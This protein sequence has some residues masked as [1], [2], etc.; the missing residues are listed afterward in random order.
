MAKY[1]GT[2]DKRLL[3]KEDEF[4]K[5]AEK[6]AQA[7]RKKARK[8]RIENMSLKERLEIFHD[9]AR[10]EQGPARAKAAGDKAYKKSIDKYKGQRKE[11]EIK[12]NYPSKGTRKKQPSACGQDSCSSK[13]IRSY[14]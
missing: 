1:Y 6:E 7:A 8:K 12:S 13:N 9:T 11:S 10:R 14:K 5:R 4:D 3:R 2:A